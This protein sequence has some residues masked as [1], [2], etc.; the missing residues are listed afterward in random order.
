MAMGSSPRVIYESG[1]SVRRLLLVT[2]LL[3]AKLREM[4][5]ILLAR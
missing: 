3:E 5:E 1:A 4:L 2:I